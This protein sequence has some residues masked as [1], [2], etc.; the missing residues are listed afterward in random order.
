M[1]VARYGD[2]VRAAALLALYA[3]LILV[4]HSAAPTPSVLVAVVV[5]GL[6][7]ALAAHAL[8]GARLTASAAV[9]ALALRRRARR[10]AYLPARDPAAPG[11]PRPRAPSGPSATRTASA[12]VADGS[13]T[14][15]P[16]EA[17]PCPLTCSPRS[18]PQ[19]RRPTAR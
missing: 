4:T 9:R 1:T 16:S 12:R 7:A 2:P 3:W 8:P 18:T 6:L 17:E 19:S 11:R 13:R 5:A 10:T 14:T 15:R